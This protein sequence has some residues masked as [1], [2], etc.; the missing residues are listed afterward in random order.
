MR[1]RGPAILL[2]LVLAA[3]G[4]GAIGGERGEWERS[5]QGNGPSA[6]LFLYYGAYD[7]NGGSTATLALIQH[8]GTGKNA[9]P[10]S[11][12]GEPVLAINRALGPAAGN[13]AEFDAW[14]ARGGRVAHVISRDVGEATL[15]SLES[16]LGDGSA[17]A[18]IGALLASGFDYVAVD[19][20]NADATS[21]R[22]GGAHAQAFVQLL[23]D[24][25]DAGLDRRLILYVNSY[26]LVPDPA[27]P[28]RPSVGSFA[29]VLR[30][31]RDRCRIVASEIYLRTGFVFKPGAETPGH[32]TRRTAC[33]EELAKRFEQV[34]PGINRRTITILGLSDLY[35]Q[36]S[37][38][39]LCA[40]PGGGAGALYLQYA[41]LHQGAL[42]RQQP[43]AGGYTLADVSN[44]GFSALDQARCLHDLNLWS[45]WPQ[46]G[47]EPAAPVP[48]PVAPAAHEHTVTCHVFADGY[49][50][51]QGPADAI[52]ARG[53][54]GYACIPGG[55]NGV[56]R[57]WL[58][59][60]VTS[61]GPDG[62]R[63][64]VGFHVFDT[65]YASQV[66][67]SDA[68]LFTGNHSACMPS[69]G[70]GI[71]RQYFGRGITTSTLGG[72]AHQHAV[73]CR[74]FEDG[75]YPISGFGDAIT[76]FGGKLHVPG[77]NGHRW[78]G[79]CRAQ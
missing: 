76:W 78:F 54:D 72:A 37:P 34:A 14:R 10:L 20:L 18:R 24:L 6:P 52:F 41:A 40:K 8:G 49:Q 28:E 44:A 7:K 12:R 59:R 60:C 70:P 57:R 4:T 56:C 73:S 64:D 42:T 32:C 27:Q 15:P 45:A 68:I 46:A 65:G 23:A 9:Q 22:D 29:Q 53:S 74:T 31:C 3:C 25:A 36:S 77:F 61:P 55:A 35:S 79:R 2:A 21:W 13:G 58:G 48:A 69:A 62:H 19:E 26:N 11:A 71:C 67:P 17:A 33:F 30:A 47:G 51:M 66:G 43:G 38:S 50:E 16:M 75:Y 1:P 63:H 5:G 39:A